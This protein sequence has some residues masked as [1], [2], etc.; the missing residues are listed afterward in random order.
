MRPAHTPRTYSLKERQ[1]SL[2]RLTGA[3]VAYLLAEHRPAIRLA[4]TGERGHYRLTPTG[5]VGTIVCPD[6]RLLI[7]PKI[8]LQNLF[9]LLDLAGPPPDF[10][11]QTTANPSAALMDLLADRL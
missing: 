9:D 6:C 8:P 2:C 1:P 7:Q 3:D 4:F 11:E 10:S 5:H